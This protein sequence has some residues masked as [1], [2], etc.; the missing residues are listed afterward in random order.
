MVY[1][2]SAIFGF[3]IRKAIGGARDEVWQ[4][5]TL[6][7]MGLHLRIQKWGF[8]WKIISEM[9][10]LCASVNSNLQVQMYFNNQDQ[11]EKKFRIRL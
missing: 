1:M 5:A 9:W 2:D 8:D 10:R 11:K 6:W 3:C 7:F 4:N